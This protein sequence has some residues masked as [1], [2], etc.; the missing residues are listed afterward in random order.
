MDLKEILGEDFNPEMTVEEVNEK[1]TEIDLVEKSALEGKVD[2]SKPDKVMSELAKANK[3]LKA[4]KTEEELKEDEFNELKEKLESLE[5]EKQVSKNTAKFIS[6]GFDEEMAEHSAQALADGEFDNIFDNFSKFITEKEKSIKKELIKKTPRPE[7]GS[8]DE[9]I[10][11]EQVKN[12]GLGELQKL[13]EAD[14]EMFKTL[15]EGD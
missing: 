2:K 7:E 11:K 9:K 15:T 3:A 14:P 1:L 10:T 13:Y 4:K 6:L 5:K 12:M 8:E